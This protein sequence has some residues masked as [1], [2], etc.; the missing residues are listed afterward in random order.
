L[1]YGEDMSGYV[2]VVAT[3]LESDEE[4][5][6]GRICEGWNKKSHHEKWCARLFHGA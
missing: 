4:W 3:F 5:D 2:V 1:D 6:I